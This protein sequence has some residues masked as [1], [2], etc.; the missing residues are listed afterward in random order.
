M[1]WPPYST[2][3]CVA[4]PDRPTGY[5][6]QTHW[7]F[8][9]DPLAVPDRPTD[10]S[11]QTHWLFQT[12]PLAVKKHVSS[13]AH[14]VINISSA[15]CGSTNRSFKGHTLYSMS[16]AGL[17]CHNTGTTKPLFLGRSTRMQHAMCLYQT[18]LPRHSFVSRHWLYNG[19]R[20]RW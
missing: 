13:S 20:L 14:S 19:R 9:T 16:S 1:V 17:C 7:L 10:Y 2:V 8:Q 4:V 18:D 3:K 11:R 15:V 6:R 12:D 5:S